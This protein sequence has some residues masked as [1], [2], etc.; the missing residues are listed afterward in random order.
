MKKL[1]SLCITAVATLAMASPLYATG[2]YLSGNKKMTESRLGT[3]QV[4]S[5]E[6]LKGM[7]VVSKAGEKLGKIESVNTDPQSGD[8]RFVT[9]SKGSILG[10]GGKDIAIPK[11]AFR[12]DQTN[13]RVLLTVSK[14]KLENVPKQA[15]LSDNEFQRNLEQHY[16]IA[17]AWKEGSTQMGTES[18]GSMDQRQQ[19]METTPKS[20]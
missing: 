2:D 6:E 5:P 3:S 9:L 15:D 14:D 13:K 19:D 20:N 10:I 7:E 4:Q 17:P 16:G 11:E 8:I 1:I 18:P 12:V